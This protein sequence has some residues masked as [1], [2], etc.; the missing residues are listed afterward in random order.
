MGAIELSALYTIYDNNAD[1]IATLN[2]PT[3]DNF[4]GY[5]TA[6][7]GLD[8]PGVRENAQTIN[9][10]DG[11]YHGPFW[12]DRRPWTI[13]GI[14][15]PTTPALSRS[16]AER[17]LSLVMNNC[18]Q[19]DGYV[20]WVD[21][22]DVT[23]FFPFR[24]QQP[25][26]FT[27]GSSPVEKEFLISGVCEDWRTYTATYNSISTDI[28]DA[29]S[30][31]G[32]T[33]LGAENMGDVVAPCKFLIEQAMANPVIVNDTTGYV[34]EIDTIYAIGS[35]QSLTVDCTGRYP[36]C[37]RSDGADLS[38]YINATTTN[39]DIGMIPGANNWR[40]YGTEVSESGNQMTVYWYDA[41]Q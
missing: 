3:D 18:F 37:L 33:A 2:N 15:Q 26:R 31:A 34:I 29:G 14:I 17:K 16:N 8:A 9:A 11:G 32:L 27:E 25:T 35:G 13:A 21:S 5:V 4:C 30:G 22:A 12:K 36:T 6:V 7:T 24:T 38:G 10:G 1:A 41:W 23:R 39:W 20:M 28:G 40:L 19:D